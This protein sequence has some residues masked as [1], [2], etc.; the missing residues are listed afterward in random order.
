MFQPFD[1]LVVEIDAVHL[2][3]V[4]QGA[5][6]HGKAVVLRSDFDLACFQIFHRLIGAAVPKLEL[7]GFGAECLPQNLMTKANPKR[8]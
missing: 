6:I 4:W 2:N 1:S 3:V 5:V 7:K 8:G